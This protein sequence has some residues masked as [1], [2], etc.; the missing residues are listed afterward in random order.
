MEGLVENGTF[1]K[2]EITRDILG[3]LGE[4]TVEGFGKS[5]KDRDTNNT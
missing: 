5:R 2:I 1:Q 4:T 3:I